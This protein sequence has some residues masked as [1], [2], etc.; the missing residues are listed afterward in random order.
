MVKHMD[1]TKILSNGWLN[2]IQMVIII[3]MF[4]FIVIASSTG[5]RTDTSIR[6]DLASARE[7]MDRIEKYNSSASDIVVGVIDANERIIDGLDSLGEENRRARDIT[8]E[9]AGDNQDFQRRI[10]AVQD[11]TLESE[12]SIDRVNQVIR[13]IERDNGY[14]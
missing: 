2:V 10:R 1:W 7:Q 9:L 5:K 8:V 14:D 11:S 13:E 6:E 12:L 4:I 3:I